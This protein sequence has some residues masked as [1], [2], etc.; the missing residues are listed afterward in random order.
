MFNLEQAIAEW[1]QRMLAAGLK[2]PEPLEEL[3]SH[4]REE[5]AARMKSGS[6][7]TEAFKLAVHNLGPASVIQNEFGKQTPAPVGRLFY[8]FGALATVD[9]VRLSHSNEALIRICGWGILA[10]TLLAVTG[11]CTKAVAVYLVTRK[12]RR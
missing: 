6:D 10:G 3:E 12:N 11:T 5:I 1:R 4:L 8:L 2:S 7:V 9:G